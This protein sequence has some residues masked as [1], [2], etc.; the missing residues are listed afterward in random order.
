M[1]FLTYTKDFQ[2]LTDLF[3]RSPDRY[4]ALAQ[5]T[6]SIMEY[7]NEFTRPQR[8]LI[9]IYVSRLN[10]CR[11]CV[12]AHRAT[13]EEMHV[14][15][16]VINA[17]EEGKSS[18]TQMAAALDFARVLTVNPGEIS[19]DN[20]AS[21]VEAGWSEQAVE[22]LICVVALFGLFN[23]LI[24]GLGIEG[25]PKH[26][27]QVGPLLAKGYSPVVAMLKKRSTVAK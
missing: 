1:P 19:S 7:D 5:F 3:M 13:L 20:I 14:E 25:S 27:A 11:F 9:A 2:G 21:M 4:H 23:R 22:D 24:D 6:T 12:S 8:E 18:D 16:E 10:G 26:F 15:S 17:A